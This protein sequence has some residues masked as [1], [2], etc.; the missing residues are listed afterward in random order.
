MELAVWLIILP[1]LTAFIL[2]LHKLY[3]DKIFYT[4]VI[5]STVIYLYLL[6]LVINYSNSPKVYS[7]G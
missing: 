3:S 7:I 4:L 5:V 1:M 2:G 6:I